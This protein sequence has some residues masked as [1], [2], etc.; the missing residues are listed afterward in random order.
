MP[1]VTRTK[2]KAEHGLGRYAD[3]RSPTCH[4]YQ[5]DNPSA[6]IPLCGTEESFTGGLPFHSGLASHTGRDLCT[7]CNRPPC[8]KCDEAAQI[9]LR[10]MRMARSYT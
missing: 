8:T 10:K 5:T 2:Y 3:T 9:L 7:R 1:K 6:P 4:V